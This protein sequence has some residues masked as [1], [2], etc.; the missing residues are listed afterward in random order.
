[1]SSSS[2]G[3]FSSALKLTDLNDF[4]TPSA[5]CVLPAGG[6]AVAGSASA[7]AGSVLAPIVPSR[8]AAAENSNATSTA[9]I[10]LSDCLSCTGC[11]T[12][13]ETVLLSST[14]LEKVKH[15][16]L[17]QSPHRNQLYVVIALSQ[18][19]VASVAVSLGLDLQATARKL[20]YF[21]THVLHVD[22]VVDASFA[23]YFAL[24]EAAVEFVQR[25]RAGDNVVIASACPGW[26]TYAEKTQG[27]DIIRAIST[28]RSPQAIVGSLLPRVMSSR[29]QPGKALCVITVMP[30]HDKKLEASRTQFTVQHS[31]VQLSSRDEHVLCVP[32]VEAVLTTDEVMQLAAEINVDIA[33]L[34]EKSLDPS[35]SAGSTAFGALAGSGSGGYADYVI[36]RASHELLNVHLP[37]GPLPWEK[38]S[39][40]GDMRSLTVRAGP[41]GGKELHF[42]TAYG[43]R[44]LQSVL[45]KIRRGDI[46]YDYIELM[47]CPGGCNNGGGQI[48]IQ[49]DKSTA[50]MHLASVEEQFMNTTNPADPCSLSAVTDVYTNVIGDKPGSPNAMKLLHTTYERRQ[51]S[52]MSSLNNW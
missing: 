25:Y 46:S 21:F 39:R 6:G 51:Q 5:T 4:L 27:H 7:P 10:T 8:D 38:A 43:F 30:C 24:E 17:K 16:L 49:G 32:E 2:R 3:T 50:A 36:R 34:S 47:A 28:V 44:S 23:R 18:Q 35:F 41:S 11:V 29:L 33:A 15:V 14:G 42:A 19:T 12:S 45:R 26:V 48:H 20:C 31:D 22:A 9:S 40:S 52:V 1:M 13:A 37:S